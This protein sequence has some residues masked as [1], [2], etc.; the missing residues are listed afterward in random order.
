MCHGITDK[1][2]HFERTVCPQRGPA[3]LCLGLRNKRCSLWMDYTSPRP[4]L[5]ILQGKRQKAADIPRRPSGKS[6]A[7]P[8]DSTNLGISATDYTVAEVHCLVKRNPG[9]VASPAALS[10]PVPV[11]DEADGGR[12]GRSCP[13]FLLPFSRLFAILVAHGTDQR[14][15]PEPRDVPDGVRKKEERVC[16]LSEDSDCG[17]SPC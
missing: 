12:M 10:F 11:G 2:L 16:F 6:N 8:A 9:G 1:M 15:R 17:I 14:V 7:I 3:T 4:Q 13:L 5:S